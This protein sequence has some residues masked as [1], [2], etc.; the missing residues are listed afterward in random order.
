MFYCVVWNTGASCKI[1][2][3][4]VPLTESAVYANADIWELLHLPRNVCLVRL[5]PP[6]LALQAKIM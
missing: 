3:F 4:G 1:N 6:E 2:Y 5:L